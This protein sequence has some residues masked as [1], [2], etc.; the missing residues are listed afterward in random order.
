MTV[1]PPTLACIL[2][3]ADHDLVK[4][5]LAVK[6]N[7]TNGFRTNLISRNYR[8]A[9]ESAR[10]SYVGKLLGQGAEAA[11]EALK[12]KGCGAELET[13]HEACCCT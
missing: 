5:T 3:L 2:R 4:G 11:T 8:L 9:M 13:F 10:R 7:A 1:I 12:H 6:A